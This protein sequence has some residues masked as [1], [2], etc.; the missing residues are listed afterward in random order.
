MNPSLYFSS[1]QNSWQFSFSYTLTISPTQLWLDIKVM[2][3]I[4]LNK[5]IYNGY[6]YFLSIF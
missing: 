3:K 5:Y 4:L 1:E 2:S 6:V